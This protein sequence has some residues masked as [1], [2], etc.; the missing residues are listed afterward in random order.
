MY[1]SEPHLR[2]K[3]KALTGMPPQDYLLHFRL[4][5]ARLSL[6]QTEDSVTSIAFD[7]GFNDPAY[8][9]R[10]FSKVYGASPLKYRIENRK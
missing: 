9:S 3:L 2:R 7:C 8:F 6:L 4:Y 10:A 1:L 5:K